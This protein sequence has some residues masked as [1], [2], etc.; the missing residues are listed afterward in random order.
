ML[1]GGEKQ[2][3][4]FLKLFTTKKHQFLHFFFKILSVFDAKW[5]QKYTL[6]ALFKL[7]STRTFSKIQLTPISSISRHSNEAIKSLF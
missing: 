2:K 5:L 1:I 3:N 6:S 7:F 4:N